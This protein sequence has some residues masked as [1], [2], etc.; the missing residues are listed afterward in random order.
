MK[1]QR[2]IVNAIKNRGTFF[3]ELKRRD[4]GRQGCSSTSATRPQ[5]SRTDERAHQITL[6][7]EIH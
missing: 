4:A 3:S 5:I 1:S 7:W 2:H 6:V